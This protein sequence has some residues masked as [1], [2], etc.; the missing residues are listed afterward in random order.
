MQSA[1][2]PNRES[3]LPFRLLVL[4]DFGF[5]ANGGIENVISSL[6]PE[7]AITSQ[8][9][10][11]VLPTHKLALATSRLPKKQSIHLESLDSSRWQPGWC[12]Q[13][14][15]SL[16]SRIDSS[17]RWLALRSRLSARAK[18]RRLQSIIRNYGLTHLLNLGVFNQPCP[19]LSI[20]VFG[21]VYDTNYSPVFGDACIRNLE[22]WTLKAQGIF[23]ISAWARQQICLKIPDA[24]DKIHEVP[25]AV[26]TPQF[27]SRTHKS[28]NLN[29]ITTFLYPASFSFHKNHKSLLEAFSILHS[30]GYDFKIVFCGYNTNLLLSTERLS[31]PRVEAARTFLA[32]CSPEFKACIRALGIV[33]QDYLER[34]FQEA[35]YVL[36][37]SIDEGFGLPLTEAVARG[38]PVLCSDIPPFREQIETYGLGKYVTI[39]GGFDPNSWSSA[40]GNLLNQP[41][42]TNVSLPAIHERLS[43]WK[44]EDVAVRYK[45]IMQ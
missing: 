4:E 28:P 27:L 33:E 38:V 35:D 1:C 41:L 3:I 32:A 31:E 24:S 15:L 39:V 20:P 16:V 45:E 11:W 22:V 37:P 26:N 12:T 21:I 13:V 23:T 30:Q 36:L 42:T 9:L 17:N 40:I 8:Q 6:L 7:L 34:L 29:G 43:K 44:W 14:V 2:P 10:V 25:I 19:D 18:R 5:T